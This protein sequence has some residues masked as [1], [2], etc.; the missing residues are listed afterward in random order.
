[1]RSIS[2]SLYLYEIADR[3]RPV[4]RQSEHLFVLDRIYG[5][6]FS[7]V[8]AGQA[9]GQLGLVITEGAC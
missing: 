6:P 3:P 7:L 1:M 5:N 4:D 8:K 9:V 2:V